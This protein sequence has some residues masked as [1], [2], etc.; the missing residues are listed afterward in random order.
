MTSDNRLRSFGLVV[1]PVD[2]ATVVPPSGDITAS[3]GHG[4]AVR[5]MNAGSPAFDP[6]AIIPELDP[7]Q[8]RL[9]GEVGDH[10][11]RTVRRP[12]VWQQALPVRTDLV[13]VDV[14]ADA[15]LT[16][17]GF[18]RGDE[19]GRVLAT[20]DVLQPETA[21]A[22]RVYATRRLLLGAPLRSAAVAQE[23]M[24]KLVGLAVLSSD[25]LS[26]VAYGPEAM[27]TVLALAGAGALG[28]AIPISAG[29]VVLMLAVGL[30]YRQTVRAYPGG[31]G[32]YIVASDNLGELPGLLAA[33]GLMIDYVLTVS[34][35]VAAGVAAVT[36]AVPSLR[37]ATVPLGLAV[38]AI[39]LVGNLRGVRKA[40]AA[41][42]WPTYAFIAAIALVVGVGMIG[43]AGR[44]FTTVR[45]PRLG[46]TEGLGLL[47]VLRAFASGSTAMTGIEAI[48]NAIPAF[49]PVEWRNAR[50]TLSWMI[51]LLITMFAGIVALIHFDGI[52]P[53]AGETVLSE[54]AH[55]TLGGGA[56]YAYVQAATA[57]V[58]L[59]AA[60]TAFNDFPRLLY[61]MA[62]DRRAPI[63]FLRMGDRLAF[64]NGIVALAVVSGF[65]FAVLGGN[66]ESLIP[67]YAVGVF[68][69]FTLSQAGMVMHWWRR[70]DPHW[71]K[72]IAFNGVGCALSAIVLAISAV[73]KFTEGAWAVLVA[74]P[75]LVILFKRIHGYYE[76]VH[77]AV[78]LR[79]FDLAAGEPSS[80]RRLGPRLDAALKGIQAPVEE[81]PEEV[82][83]LAVVP[84]V[85]LNL[86]SMRALAYAAS[87]GQPV[88]AVHISPNESEAA[89]FEAYW[90]AWGDHLPL[91]VVVSPYRA[92]VGPLARYLEE[93]HGQRPDVT[94]TV[95]V[96]ELVPRRTWQRLLQGGTAGR[97]RR[98]L[99]HQSR[100]I[101]TTA[102]F[103]LP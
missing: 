36:S 50:T 37:G 35:S 89:R 14:R 9:L 94:L 73:T 78:A 83:N 63:V 6:A 48:S 4:D 47:L 1:N 52:A 92:I 54:L 39:L 79:P 67:L 60:N 20:A 80:Q 69:A 95:I 30:S 31:G 82:H 87:L 91:E 44:G 88:L 2:P 51:G 40:G 29:I 75:L 17:G 53:R 81:S 61:F 64:Y 58:L 13:P 42:A 103:L 15:K 21:M 22:R 100:T 26:S 33:A 65:A 12:P 5:G 99:R 86:A 97:L 66:T 10:W 38:I 46:V 71:R 90:H 56:L 77:S 19:P 24:R 3:G 74:V 76:M 49:K 72:S 102:P 96:P 16:N 55:S 41:F 27:I 57:L 59:L 28:Y 34:V 25:A 68:L 84:I 43:V 98:S 101:V 32:S 11:T 7:E 45:P 62:R 23:R 18:A 70:R 85:G 8:V 93:L